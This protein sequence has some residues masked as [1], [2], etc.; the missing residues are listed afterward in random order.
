MPPPF[1]Q[2][3]R[4]HATNSCDN[5][6]DPPSTSRT[7]SSSHRGLSPG[8]VS[9]VQARHCSPAVPGPL[10]GDPWHIANLVMMHQTIY[11]DF[12]HSIIRPFGSQ[13]GKRISTWC[14]PEKQLSPNGL[15]FMKTLAHPPTPPRPGLHVARTRRHKPDGRQMQT[16]CLETLHPLS[17]SGAPSWRQ[18]CENLRAGRAAAQGTSRLWTHREEQ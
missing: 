12:F 10:L 18:S 2:R 15:S 11:P 5:S 14:W 8:M 13:T 1:S 17:D 16:W 3:P 6:L 9:N 4:G 7:W